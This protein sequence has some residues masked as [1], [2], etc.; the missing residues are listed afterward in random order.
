MPTSPRCVGKHSTPKRQKRRFLPPFLAAFHSVQKQQKER[1]TNKQVYNLTKP[2]SV[3]RLFFSSFPLFER[4][5]NAI[6]AVCNVMHDK[7][8][9]RLD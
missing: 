1:K 5:K 4:G 7:P 3:V 6:F 8:P 9:T 2:Q